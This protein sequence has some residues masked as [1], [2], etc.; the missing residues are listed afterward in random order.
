MTHTGGKRR[1]G[2][3]ETAAHAMYFKGSYGPMRA[4]GNRGSTNSHQP[5]GSK[6]LPVVFL[7]FFLFGEGGLVSIV[8]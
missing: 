7:I 6:S 2:E 4:V 5:T 3:P 1:G 8:L